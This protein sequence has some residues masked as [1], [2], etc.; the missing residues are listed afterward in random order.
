MT[1]VCEK[2]G[3]SF[4]LFFNEDDP[5]Y[6][7]LACPVC[8]ANEKNRSAIRCKLDDLE[9]LTKAIWARNDNEAIIQ[10]ARKRVLQESTET[11]NQEAI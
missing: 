9:V 3:R 7:F 10:Q 8:A 4:E 11:D 2:C 5:V 6:D 1:Y